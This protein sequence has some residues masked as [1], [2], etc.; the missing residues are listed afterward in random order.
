MIKSGT[1]AFGFRLFHFSAQNQRKNSGHNPVL[2]KVL[3][4]PVDSTLGKINN[5]KETFMSPVSPVFHTE[6]TVS[7]G[8]KNVLRVGTSIL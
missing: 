1:P 4:S 5:I 7:I 8:L 2:I 6:A 3:V